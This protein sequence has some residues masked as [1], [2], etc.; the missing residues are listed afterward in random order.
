M[1]E[2]NVQYGK[3]LPQAINMEEG[4]IGAMLVDLKAWMKFL[5]V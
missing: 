2:N 4:V 3:L 1:S 5:A